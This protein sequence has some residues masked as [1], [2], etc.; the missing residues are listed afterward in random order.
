MGTLGMS[1]KA[2]VRCSSS[3][4]SGGVTSD[5]RRAV[6]IYDLRQC[7]HRRRSVLAA[8]GARRYLNNILFHVGSKGQSEQKSSIT[9]SI[10]SLA[11]QNLAKAMGLRRRQRSRRYCWKERAGDD[12][13]S[14]RRILLVR[15]RYRRIV[16]RQGPRPLTSMT[17]DIMLE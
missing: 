9:K 8:D 11:T 3:G 15:N 10:P 17:L 4:E 2:S 13:D 14:G 12:L 6:R 1:L 7:Y 5:L 16:T